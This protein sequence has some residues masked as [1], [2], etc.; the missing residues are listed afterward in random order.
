MKNG[1]L[2]RIFAYVCAVVFCASYLYAS[3]AED[4]E[5]GYFLEETEGD[6]YGAMGYYLKASR[7]TEDAGL[8]ARALYRLGRCHE[9]LGETSRAQ[10]VYREILDLE[11]AP[12]KTRELAA[13]R[14][15]AL[16]GSARSKGFSVELESAAA[17]VAEL[18]NLLEKVESTISEMKNEIVRR[19]KI[20][21]D[22]S[23]GEKKP[24]PG[25][26][27]TSTVSEIVNRLI[28]KE[29]TNLKARKYLSGHF[30]KTGLKLYRRLEYD[31]ALIE[32]RKAAELD[33]D[34]REAVAYIRRILYIMGKI[35][36]PPS[37]S[38]SAKGLSQ[39]EKA[40]IEVESLIDQAGK[41]YAAGDYKGAIDN[42]EKSLDIVRWS[43]WI[44]DSEKMNSLVEAINGKI[45]DALGR[46]SPE[47]SDKLHSRKKEKG[48]IIEKLLGSLGRLA[49]TEDR[50]EEAGRRIDRLAGKPGKSGPRAGEE[51][52]TLALARA[53]DLMEK[54]FLER[55]RTETLDI[56]QSD[57]SNP[58]AA[59][60]LDEIAMRADPEKKVTADNATLKKKILLAFEEGLAAYDRR[61]HARARDRFERVL[62]L[63]D[64]APESPVKASTLNRSRKLLEELR[65][66]LASRPPGEDVLVIDVSALTDGNPPAVPA[67]RLASFVR[68]AA[69]LEKRDASVSGGMLTVF[70]KP[71]VTRK[72][73]RYVRT[74]SSPGGE[75]ADMR[76]AVIAV[77]DRFLEKEDIRFEP[78]GEGSMVSTLSSER[79]GE[80]IIRA[81]SVAS[82]EVVFEETFQADHGVEYEFRAGKWKEYIAGYEDR[83]E[84]GGKIAA[85]RLGKVFR[86]VRVR[87]RVFL[88]RGGRPLSAWDV[89]TSFLDRGFS[90]VRT[91]RGNVQVPLSSKSDSL[92]L[93][94]FD[95]GGALVAEGA[96]N[97]LPDE[98]P[99]EAREGELARILFVLVNASR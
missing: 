12:G 83:P 86:G 46:L 60:L 20:I 39:T 45:E 35:E 42:L 67:G 85:P 40:V 89:E 96:G 87:L 22:Y 33:P 26:A 21:S 31:K 77:E 8:K 30:H 73:S 65:R 59:N 14:V 50:L 9:K 92:F 25:E 91:A 99:L 51:T 61:E 64:L 34:N 37:E 15:A 28:D 5:K 11:D 70:G 58:E 52:T 44:L 16:R 29:E 2:V 84:A 94:E 62:R 75:A 63:A 56:L 32:F 13:G 47:G 18:Q 80:L 38:L 36:T 48:E 55:A 3:P 19:E 4:F 76:L 88:P 6:V 41:A 81:K 17:E 79:A 53:R 82:A 7:S 72:V 10:T 93:V 27:E 74:M 23:T 57:P 98:R 69:G 78:A 24:A 54:G 1:L 68:A 90:V 95:R 49:E 71:L 97:P 43:P 66:R